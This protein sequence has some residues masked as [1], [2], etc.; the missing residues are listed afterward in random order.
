MI[1]VAGMPHNHVKENHSSE[2][3]QLQDL[4]A[5]HQPRWCTVALSVHA[6]KVT[7]MSRRQSLKASKPVNASSKA[8]EA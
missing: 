1:S 5:Y 3:Q 4:R 6:G 7:I 8:E 2:Y